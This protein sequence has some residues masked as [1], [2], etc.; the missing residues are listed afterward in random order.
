MDPDSPSSNATTPETK[1]DGQ[2]MAPV[3]SPEA[4]ANPAEAAEAAASPPEEPAEPAPPAE[5]PIE[6]VASAPV[7][8]EVDGRGEEPDLVELE[9]ELVQPPL[10]PSLRP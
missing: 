5:L 10:P 6:P 3:V 4:E 9:P 2:D 8:T 7:I 1:G